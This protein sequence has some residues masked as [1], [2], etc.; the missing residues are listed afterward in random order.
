MA[1]AG[2]A[3]VRDPSNAD[4]R[5]ARIRLRAALAD[6]AGERRRD[7][8]PGRGGRG[9]RGGGGAA[10]SGA[11]PSR[12]AVA[13]CLFPEGFAEI[14]PAALGGDAVADAALA[15]LVRVV[16]G[17]GF[18]PPRAA[19]RG[20]APARAAARWR[21]A[22]L[23]AAGAGWRLLRE[24]A[25]V[26]PPVAGRLRAR[27]GTGASGWPAAGRAA[28]RSARWAPQAAGLRRRPGGACRP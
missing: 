13:A 22:W 27:S 1:A 16:G 26:A 28:A 12:L 14:D 25:A 11:W 3:P 7:R 4:P 17:A 2:L 18:P 21:G 8:G 23:R 24:P 15:A 9:L 5:F 10:W 6:S 20:A 19:V